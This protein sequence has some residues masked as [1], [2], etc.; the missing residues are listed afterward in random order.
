MNPFMDGGSTYEL[1]EYGQS[2]EK[3]LAIKVTRVEISPISTDREE[4][5]WRHFIQAERRAG[6]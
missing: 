3:K 1:L 6:R 2:G 4:A 5:F